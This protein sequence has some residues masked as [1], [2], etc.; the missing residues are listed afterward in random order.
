MKFEKHSKS[1]DVLGFRYVCCVEKQNEY[2][3]IAVNKL[4]KL[5]ISST[6]FIVTNNDNYIIS[7][8]QVL[9]VLPNS[10]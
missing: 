6:E 9:Q 3:S 4:K 2:K 1:K 7:T 10:K 8:D 5:G